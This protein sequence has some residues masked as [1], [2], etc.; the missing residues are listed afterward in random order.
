MS[1]LNNEQE[2]VDLG[3]LF[4]LIGKAF[5]KLINFI[6]SIFRGL[7]DFIIQILLFLKGNIIKI[8]IA[9]L[10]GA[11]IGG[12]VHL[13]SDHKFE[14][15]LLVKPNFKS[16]R[17][18]YNNIAYYNDLVKQKDTLLLASTFNISV[19]EAKSLKKFEITPIVNNNDIIA[20][21]DELLQNIDTTTIK[22]FTFNDYKNAF[23][24]YD[25]DVH[26]IRVIATQNNVF[27]KLSNPIISSITENQ[28]FKKLKKLNQE[29]LEKSNN[30]LNKNLSQTDSLFE[31][32]K[33]T[34]VLEAQKGVPSTQ[35]NMNN[36]N[37]MVKELA[38]FETNLL[39]D[40]ELK[41]ISDDLTKKSEIINIISNFQ[42]I[43]HQIKEIQRNSTFQY[44]L[45][46][47]ILMI[48]FLLFIKLN[49]YLEKYKS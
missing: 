47:S 19:E 21:Y 44:A 22:S 29:S 5:T 25:Y 34:L 13:K 9:A 37:K 32:Y 14:A 7:F 18:L 41:E 46:S 35:I 4:I 27:S 43:G 3:S 10:F 26:N 30:L 17:Q 45:I 8:G 40:E 1:Q 6:T 31:V 11:I 28:Y 24:Y 42:P 15:N 20:A 16:S 12:F 38:L 48:A 33:K 39:L 23:T 36:T 2:E 49:T